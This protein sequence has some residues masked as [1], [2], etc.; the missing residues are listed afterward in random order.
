M[1]Y[2]K[3]QLGT[4][5]DDKFQVAMDTCIH[6]TVHLI[7]IVKAIPKLK[8]SDDNETYIT[9]RHVGKKSLGATKTLPLTRGDL[10]PAYPT[11]AMTSVHLFPSFRSAWG[12]CSRMVAP[13]LLKH[14]KQQK[15]CQGASVGVS[16][17]SSCFISAKGRSLR[18][19]TGLYFFLVPPIDRKAKITKD[20]ILSSVLRGWVGE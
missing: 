2:S 6:S 9:G 20:S 4:F 18:L 8:A 11:D 15:P 14:N 5:P 16:N 7:N 12:F 13:L 17:R 3:T 19:S 1:L 10:V